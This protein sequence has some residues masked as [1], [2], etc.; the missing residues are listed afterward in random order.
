MMKNV[1]DIVLGGLT[2]W[3]FGFGFSFGLYEPTNPFVGVGGLFVDPPIEDEYMGAICAAFIFQL[4]FA[5]T[6]T[7]IVSGAM[8]ERY[9]SGFAARLRDGLCV[10]RKPRI[11]LALPD[12]ISRR[13]A[14]SRSSTPSCTAC[15]PAGCGAI[16]AFSIAWGWLISPVRDRCISLV[17]L[18]VYIHR[19]Y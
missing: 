17:A 11:R 4:S 9:L 8:A 6:S 3:F 12:V 18:R 19:G 16:T 15:R 10:Y 7:T 14:S 5:T 13:T 1:V 2:Y